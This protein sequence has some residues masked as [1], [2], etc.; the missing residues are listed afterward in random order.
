MEVIKTHCTPVEWKGQWDC[1]P[2]LLFLPPLPFSL[3]PLSHSLSHW[4]H[5]LILGSMFLL[6]SVLVRNPRNNLA[7]QPTLYL[8]QLLSTLCMHIH[9]HTNF[10]V[11]RLLSNSSD[12]RYSWLLLGSSLVPYSMEVHLKFQTLTPSIVEMLCLTDSENHVTVIAIFITW[13]SCDIIPLW[14]N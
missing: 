14:L 2:S 8:L 9:I 11:T 10:V 5:T 13:L 12:T 1:L 6:V 4:L 3:P 7:I